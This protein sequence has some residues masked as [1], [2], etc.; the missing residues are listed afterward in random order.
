ML[1]V[2]YLSWLLTNAGDPP[3]SPSLRLTVSPSSQV[4]EDDTFSILLMSSGLC[5]SNTQTCV[6]TRNGSHICPESSGEIV[7]VQSESR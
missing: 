4:V 1:Y 2:C 7:E 5:L 3:N 6:W